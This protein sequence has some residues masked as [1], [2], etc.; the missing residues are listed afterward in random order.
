MRVHF[1]SSYRVARN[2][3]SK[4]S[5][6]SGV[7]DYAHLMFHPVGSCRHV[8]ARLVV[9]WRTDTGAGGKRGRKKGRRD[10]F[11]TNSDK[12]LLNKLQSE[13]YFPSG[14]DNSVLL[15]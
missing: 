13:Y 7:I 8:G 11:L 12:S 5:G 3:K 14:C 6:D 2:N 9:S 1:R 4:G 10:L 15:K